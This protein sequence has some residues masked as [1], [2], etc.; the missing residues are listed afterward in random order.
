MMREKQGPNIPV[1]SDNT[2]KRP[3]AFGRLDALLSSPSV[4]DRCFG[5]LRGLQSGP[6]IF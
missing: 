6:L 2:L 5:N 1:R 4:L 3:S